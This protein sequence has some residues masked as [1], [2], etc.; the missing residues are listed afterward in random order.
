MLKSTNAGQSWL[1]ASEP[2]LIQVS[3]LAIDL[4]ASSN[5]YAGLVSNGVLKSTDGGVS[6]AVTPLVFSQGKTVASLAIDP[7]NPTTLYAGSAG[8]GGGVFKTLYRGQSWAQFLS[9][10][11][12]SVSLD[13]LSP[14]VVYAGS[15]TGDI[16]KSTDGGQTW[17]SVRT[18]IAD[19]S[20]T[21][22]LVESLAVDPTV[23]TT[24]YAGTFGAGVLKSVDGG[25]T[26]AALNTGL[27]TLRILRLTIDPAN[28]STIYAATLG[29][30]VFKSTDAAQTWQPTGAN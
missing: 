19:A 4:S 8:I 15:A 26:W 23:S 2:S 22:A 6:W 27:S 21:P 14:A 5:V 3:S 13:P 30:G 28:P 16:Y 18:G 24:V 29:A 17:S 25:Q 7:V 9:N 11:I 1:P 10:S 12:L 20:G